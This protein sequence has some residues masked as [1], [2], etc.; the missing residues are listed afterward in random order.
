MSLGEG[1]GRSA[2]ILDQWL[3]PAGYVVPPAFTLGTAPRVDGDVRG[4]HRNNI[5]LSVGKNIR[6]G[7]SVLGEFRVEVINLTNT[8][9]VIGPIHSV[10]SSGFGQI[11]SQSG[12]MRMTQFTFRLTF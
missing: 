6:F 7:G 3:T 5:D 11:R 12:F 10:G 2:R 8:V 4:P 9:K 1:G